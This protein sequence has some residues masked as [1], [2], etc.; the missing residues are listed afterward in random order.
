MTFNIEH[1][2]MVSRLTGN[3][4]PTAAAAGKPVVSAAQYFADPAANAELL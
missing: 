1:H 4:V 3:L 2:T